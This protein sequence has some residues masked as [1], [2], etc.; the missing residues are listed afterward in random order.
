MSQL[1]FEVNTQLRRF[2]LRQTVEESGYFTQAWYLRGQGA[3]E[4]ENRLGFRTGRLGAGW[5]L[6]FM[7]EIPRLEEFE[8]RGHTHLSGGVIRGHLKNPPDPRTAEQR[9]KDEGYDLTRLKER[10][11]AAT[12]AVL[13]HK[14]LAKVVPV[15]PPFGAAD[16]PVGS[17]IPQW[18]L[19]MKKRFTVAEFVGPGETY[20][21]NYS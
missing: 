18:E 3:C 9:L 8:F 4:L 19:T 11:I 16:Y 5:W 12:F 1:D 14:R 15:T 21:G 20:Q 6:L 13:G 7:V 17:G 10:T 2:E